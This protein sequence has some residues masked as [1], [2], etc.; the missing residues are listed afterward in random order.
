MARESTKRGSDM[1]SSGNIGSHRQCG[2]KKR[3]ECIQGTEPLEISP[4]QDTEERT[5]CNRENAEPR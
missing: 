5:D 4:G 2:K 1:K 3:R